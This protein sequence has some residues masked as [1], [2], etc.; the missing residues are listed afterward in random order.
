MLHQ[1]STFPGCSAPFG[2]TFVVCQCQHSLMSDFH[3][4]LHLVMAARPLIHALIS[5]Y[6]NLPGKCS[7]EIQQLAFRGSS[8]A[9]RS[10]AF[11]AVGASDGFI[12]YIV[13]VK[14]GQLR[15]SATNS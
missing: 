5:N 11:N 3:A 1:A 12:H 10:E 6:A 2:V 14:G 9:L 7:A 15:A 8:S 13:S 4:W